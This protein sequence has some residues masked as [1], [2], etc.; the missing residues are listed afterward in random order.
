MAFD[1]KKW[2]QEDMGFSEADAAEMAPKF[3][4][5]RVA[6]IEAGIGDV[7]T[8]AAAM[9]AITKTQTDL[10]A[11]NERLNA[12]MAEWASLTAKEKTESTDLRNSLEAARVR[13]TQLETRLT[14]LA[15]QHGVDPKPLLEGT[16]VVPP[17]PEKPAAPV[18]DPRLDAF[19]HAL[20]FNLDLTANL[21]WIQDQHRQLTGE[22]L[23]TREIV[24]AIKANA[25]K[26]DAI[27]DPVALWEEKYGIPAKRA[28]KATA[29]HDKEIADAEARGE[30]RARTNAALPGPTAPG[31]H[32]PVFGQRGT[33]GQITPRTSHLSRPQ[34]QQGVRSAAAALASGKYRQKPATV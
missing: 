29:D 22:T 27:I 32:A 18:A 12:E 10:A 30:E 13:A 8:R 25:G 5:D 31:R 26:K 3:T 15:T 14:N 21:Q 9:A 11:A 17:T 20:N 34:P 33:N 6:K 7:A 2:L 4:A 24:K 1:I 19:G 23:D 16:A 28:A